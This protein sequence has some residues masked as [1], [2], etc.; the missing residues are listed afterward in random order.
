MKVLFTAGGH[1]KNRECQEEMIFGGWQ[2]QHTL[3][4]HFMTYLEYPWFTDVQ[5][6]DFLKK[7]FNEKGPKADRRPVSSL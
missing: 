3:K 7:P 1:C 4:T 2:N 6:I 5:N